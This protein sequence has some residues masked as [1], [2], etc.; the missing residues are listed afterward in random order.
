MS[1]FSK[2]VVAPKAVPTPRPDARTGEALLTA[3]N[4][5]LTSNNFVLAR[6]LLKRASDRLGGPPSVL[7][8]IAAVAAIQEAIEGK[9]SA[10][11]ADF[12]RLM[13]VAPEAFD[14]YTSLIA[15]QTYLLNA[16]PGRALRVFGSM[17][18]IPPDFHPLLFPVFAC[19]AAI[20][21]SNFR[22]AAELLPEDLLSG[23][24]ED[25]VVADARVLR[26]Q[27]LERLAR[28]QG[29]RAV[30]AVRCA[31]CGAPRFPGRIQCLY[32]RAAYPLN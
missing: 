22:L 25:S 24:K 9:V 6:D 19:R 31:N 7:H 14:P 10:S 23:Q 32:C 5:A 29:K 2:K 13:D 28:E 15:V 26:A 3:A 12:D 1:L 20:A 4:E 16:Q 8:R 21:L 11:C 17:P 18:P 27:I 30:S